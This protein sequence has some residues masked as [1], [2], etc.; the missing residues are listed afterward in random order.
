[1][2][3]G[4]VTLFGCCQGDVSPLRISQTAHHTL[5]IIVGLC[6]Q[7]L[8][9]WWHNLMAQLPSNWCQPYLPWKLSLGHTQTTS[10]SICNHSGILGFFT[11]HCLAC[12]NTCEAYDLL[13]IGD[14]PHSWLI[15]I[16]YV[17]W[18][19][20]QFPFPDPLSELLKE[21]ADQYFIGTFSPM[22]WKAFGIFFFEVWES[23]QEPFKPVSACHHFFLGWILFFCWQQPIHRLV[24]SISCLWK[25]N[26][27]HRTLA[28]L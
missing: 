24:S 18:F 5:Q 10:R 11:S 22:D 17:E 21:L 1:M 14:I 6:N 2:S 7:F 28:P 3:P 19:V 8:N 23:F 26:P 25:G 12:R 9:T 4:V 15:K 20:F 13:F 27:F 16:P